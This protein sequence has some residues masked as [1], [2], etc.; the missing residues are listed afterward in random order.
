MN[1]APEVPL[2]P[3]YVGYKGQSIQKAK[4][5]NGVHLAQQLATEIGKDLQNENDIPKQNTLEKFNIL[6]QVIRILNKKQIEE[7]TRQLYAPQ[8]DNQSE[9]SSARNAAW[10]A[11]RDAVAQAGTGPAV[12][13][14]T[15]WIEAK[16]V[17]GE[18]AAQLIAT[19]PKTI[20]EPTEE[21]MKLFFVSRQLTLFI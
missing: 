18:E 1:N 9:K 2:L 8:A 6:A 11:Y 14:L 12:K 13:E 10:K 5:I 17:D 16:K 7:A 20:R 15:E 21:M 19:L 4:N 3:L